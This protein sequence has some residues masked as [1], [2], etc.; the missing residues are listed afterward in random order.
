VSDVTT[1]RALDD[2]ASAAI[3]PGLL[4]DA[5]VM[6]S[7]TLTADAVTRVKHNLGR[8]AK[9]YL[10]I[11][12]RNVAVASV[13]RLMSGSAFYP[14]VEATNWDQPGGSQNYWSTLKTNRTLHLPLP[15]AVGETLTGISVTTYNAAAA[16]MTFDTYY[17]AYND[18]SASAFSPTVTWSNQPTTTWTKVAATFS[19][20]IA[21]DTDYYLRIV[22]PT[23]GDRIR[24]A[25][26]SVKPTTMPVVV[27][28]NDQHGDLDKF[29]YLKSVGG[30]MTVDLAVF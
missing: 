28:E 8:R 2:L 30:S 29:L 1:A 18:A 16:D 15:V 22:G 3:G 25:H 24:M 20:L 14:Y 26:V 27:D 21:A 9:G 11:G 17:S 5:V 6:E 19:Q 13:T 4:T 10:I 23:I 12:R 7:V